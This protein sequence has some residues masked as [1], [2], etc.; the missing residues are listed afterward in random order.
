[1]LKSIPQRNF[2]TKMQATSTKNTKDSA[3]RRLGV[4][5]LGGEIVYPNDIIIRQRG[6]KW[7]PGLN[8]V[9]GRDHT[10]HSRIEGVVKFTKEFQD[11]RKY[12][13]AHVLPA[14]VNKVKG[15]IIHPFCYHPEMYP[16]LAQ[17]NPEPFKRKEIKSE[18]I[19]I[20]QKKTY[21]LKKTDTS[22]HMIKLPP[23]YYEKESLPI[24]EDAFKAY[25]RELE[26]RYQTIKNYMETPKMLS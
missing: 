23:Q 5:N 9:M 17:F 24:E 18:K 7:L 4:K 26:E 15:K 1:M 8:T 25:E 2:A 20:K 19:E 13:T 10:I 16:E 14:R 11:G 22:E 12:T 21:Q 3:G 6:T